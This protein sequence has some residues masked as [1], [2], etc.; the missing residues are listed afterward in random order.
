MGGARDV[1]GFGGRLLSEPAPAERRG[2][3][4][5]STVAFFRD[6]A[7]LEGTWAGALEAIARRLLRFS[8]DTVCDL[9]VWLRLQL[10]AR[11]RSLQRFHSAGSAARHAL[12]AAPYHTSRTN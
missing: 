12:K 7:G 9:F 1:T 6:A 5:T 3:I 2:V 11:D 10:G 4:F 8:R